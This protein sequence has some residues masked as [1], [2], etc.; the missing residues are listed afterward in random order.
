MLFGMC[1]HPASQSDLSLLLHA[2]GL[3][4][5]SLHVSQCI[6]YILMLQQGAGMT[7]RCLCAMN[8]ITL[9]QLQIF[10]IFSEEDACVP[11]ELCGYG[12]SFQMNIVS[13]GGELSPM[14]R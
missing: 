8:S 5:Y 4:L 9:K 6:R 10:I 3:F 14:P 13:L 1:L 12:G 7:S 11:T 2:A